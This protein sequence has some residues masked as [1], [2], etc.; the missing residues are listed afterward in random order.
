MATLFI[1][2]QL[3]PDLYLLNSQQPLLFPGDSEILLEF[4]PTKP[5]KSFKIIQFCTRKMRTADAI[6]I[7][8]T[9]N[10]IKIFVLL[11]KDFD[12]VFWRGE[13]VALAQVEYI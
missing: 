3:L 10:L 12:V 4:R 5:V 7:E 6:R 1:S 11:Q 13:D 9:G 2:K 8:N